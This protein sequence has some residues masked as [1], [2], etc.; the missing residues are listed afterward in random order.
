MIR[1]VICDDEKAAGNIIRYF[2]EDEKL[3]INIVG[4]AV[5]GREAL[6]LIEREKPDL[7]F[8]DINMPYMNGFEVITQ[9]PETKFIVITAYD[10]FSYAQKALRLGARDIISKPID[11][12]QLKEAIN[13]AVGWNFTANDTVNKMLW[14]IHT[15]YTENISLEDLEEITYCTKSHISRLFK[16]HMEVSI[17]NYIHEL[18]IEKAVAYLKEGQLG[19]QEISEKVGYQNLNNFYKYFKQQKGETPAAYI[20]NQKAGK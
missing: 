7:V 15:H 12:S 3:P 11:L 9:V 19:I 16:K 13:R 17:L 6:K 1:A 18:R 5:N 10:S 4:M 2:I 14:Y 20:Q 8:M